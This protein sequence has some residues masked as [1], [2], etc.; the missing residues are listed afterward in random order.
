MEVTARVAV[1]ADLPSLAPLVAEG[2]AAVEGERGAQLWLLEHG[3]RPPFAE[4]LE[5]RSYDPAANVIAGCVDGVPVGVLLI[6]RRVLVDGRALARVTFVFVHPRA[7]EI[8]VG[9]ALIA[10]ATDWALASDCVGI[11]GL[12]LPGDRRTKNLYERSGMTAREITVHREL[13]S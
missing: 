2:V 6:D 12:A 13:R 1:E 9:E 10:A 5:R 4:D 7:R 11:D 8:G 3:P